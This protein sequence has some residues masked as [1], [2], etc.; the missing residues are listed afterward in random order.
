MGAVG[1]EG[2]VWA[3]WGKRGVFGRRG[4]RGEYLGAVGEEGS[5]WAQWGIR[6]VFGRGGGRGECLGAMGE[7][8]SIWAPWGKRGVF[9]RGG[10]RWECLGPVG[11]EGSVWAQWGKRGLFG[12][13]S[14]LRQLSGWCSCTFLDFYLCGS[15]FESHSDPRSRHVDWVFSPYLITLIFQQFL[16]LHIN[17]LLCLAPKVSNSKQQGHQP[18]SSRHLTVNGERIS[19]KSSPVSSVRR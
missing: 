8:E 7:E 13:P 4:G 10:E 3:R 19:N 15:G 11:E 18:V 16:I 1:E 12:F 17:L 5:V 2:S 9:G 14:L 6:R